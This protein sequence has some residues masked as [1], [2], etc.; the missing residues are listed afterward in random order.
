[1]KTF[2]LVVVGLACL[3]FIVAQASADNHVWKARYSNAEALYQT[4]QWDRV[5]REAKKAAADA[6]QRFGE[7]HLNTAKALNPPAEICGARGSVVQGTLFRKR[8]LKVQER[9]FGPNHPNTVK[10]LTA[11]ADLYRADGKPGQAERFQR[12]A[13][14]RADRGGWGSSDYAAPALEGPT[15]LYMQKGKL[16]EAASPKD[17]WWERP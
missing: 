10:S 16:T 14:A 5:F 7:Y 17:P 9:L 8:A 2:H 15:G 13:L 11:I 3:L 1:M 6:G 4:G 12:E